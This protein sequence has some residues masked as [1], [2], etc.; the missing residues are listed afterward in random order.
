MSFNAMAWASKQKTGNPT[1][2]L[3]LL[4]L[5]NN[6]NDEGYCWPSISTIARDCEIKKDAVIRNIRALE[7]AGLLKVVRR[8]KDGVN[9]PNHYQLMVGVREGG[10]VAQSDKGSSSERQGVVAQSDSNLSTEPVNET[11]TPPTPSKKSST[12][13]Q[14]TL[15]LP[16]WLDK[17]AWDEWEQ[18][19][20]EIGKKI[21]PAS[22]RKQLKLLEQY[23]SQQREIIEQSILSGWQG[24]FPPKEFR[25]TGRSSG[26]PEPGSLGW[27]MQQRAKQGGVTDVEVFDE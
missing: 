22:M 20:R 1:R 6:A 11:I 15:D 25:A 7:E 10:V 8:K 17:E 18:H 19:R 9:L 5:A 2:K 4:M 14:N 16:D 13:K 23:K 27:I 21:T 3:I 26:E 24:L 12:K